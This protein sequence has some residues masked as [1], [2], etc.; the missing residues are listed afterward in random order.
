MI[1]KEDYRLKS[2]E[3][4]TAVELRYLKYILKLFAYGEIFGAGLIF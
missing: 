1:K 2:T 4:V 3:R